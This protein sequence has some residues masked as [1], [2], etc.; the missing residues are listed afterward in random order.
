MINGLSDHYAQL[1]ELHVANLDSI[2]IN[3]KTITIRKIGSNTVNEFRDKLSS[4]LF[5]KRF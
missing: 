4:E 2:R 3:Y 1:L 5:A